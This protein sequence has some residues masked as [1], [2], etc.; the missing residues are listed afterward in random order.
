MQ[1]LHLCEW[2]PGLAFLGSGEH[3]RSSTWMSFPGA[4]PRARA[5]GHNKVGSQGKANAWRQLR[6]AS[7][8]SFFLC[9]SIWPK[10]S[11]GKGWLCAYHIHR[12]NSSR[13]AWHGTCSHWKEPFDGEG[14]CVWEMLQM[15]EALTTFTTFL[16]MATRLTKTLPAHVWSHLS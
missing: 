7:F 14:S 10:L 9:F 1:Q 8:F 5:G 4:L 15:R 3:P 16:G 2:F 11:A 12:T 13:I 6:T